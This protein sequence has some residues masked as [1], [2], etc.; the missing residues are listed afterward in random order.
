[1]RLFH[2]IGKGESGA[3]GTPAPFFMSKNNSRRSSS[4]YASGIKRI[5][6]GELS[7]I[8]FVHQATSLGFQVSKPFSN[9]EPYDFIV[10]SGPHLW[11]V[12]VK[13]TSRVTGR[14]Y[15]VSCGRHFGRPLPRY[16]ASQLDFFAVHIK[17]E[18]SWYIFPARIV[19]PHRYLYLL[20]TSKNDDGSPTQLMPYRGRAAH[21]FEPYREA[22]H[23]MRE[24]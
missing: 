22:W 3:G 20:R 12:Q 10:S 8:A 17:P 24:K 16:L 4:S 21:Q 7:E 23:L 11:R 18:D 9:S 19:C 14:C 13:S 6:S 15:H 2:F 5:R 1:L